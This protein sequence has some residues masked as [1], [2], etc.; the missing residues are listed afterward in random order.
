M[1]VDWVPSSTGGQA[2]VGLAGILYLLLP[3][4]VDDFLLYLDP[5]YCQ[6]FVDATQ[7]NFPL[8]VRVFSISL[9]FLDCGEAPYLCCG[10]DSA[11]VGQVELPVSIATVGLSPEA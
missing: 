11:M 10:F 2:P 1:G 6:P 8:E 9:K 7:E 3:C 4:L 5:H